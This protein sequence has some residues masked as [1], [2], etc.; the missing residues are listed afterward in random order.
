MF[1]VG[2]IDSGINSAVNPH[3]IIASKDFTDSGS[4]IDLQGHGSTV[5]SIIESAAL[6]ALADRQT[7]VSNVTITDSVHLFIAKIF[8][9]KLSCNASLVSDAIQWLVSNDV[10]IINM[11][12]GLASDRGT[13][14]QSCEQALL[15]NT[16]LI[17]AA[18]AHGQAVYPANYP[19]VLRATGDAR[20]QPG[21]IAHLNSSQ[22]DFA[23]FVGNPNTGIAGA[24]IGCAHVSAA[25]LHTLIRHNTE[26]TSNTRLTTARACAL[27]QAQARF[28]GRERHEN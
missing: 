19:G 5:F 20:C 13:I 27:L 15:N 12:F 1:K 7:T 24:S 25:L 6:N 28:H 16:V 23:G 11:S 8:S 21:D 4:V 10:D 2:I 18:P 14:K 9:T 17:A 3:L 26:P 22:A